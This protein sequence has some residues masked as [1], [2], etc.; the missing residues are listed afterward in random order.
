MLNTELD[1][2]LIRLSTMSAHVDYFIILESPITFTGLPK[3]LLLTESNNLERLKPYQHKIVHR[4]LEH[5]PV[6]VTRTWDYEDFQRNAMLTQGLLGIEYGEKRA[7]ED[8]V[9]IVADVDEVVRPEALLVLKYCRIPLRVTLRSQFYYYGFQFR[10]IGQQWPHPQATLYRGSSTIPPAD[11][12]N[13]EGSFLAWWQKTDLW[14]AGWHCSSCFKS[15]GQMLNKMQSFSHMRLNREKFRDKA[16]MV[17]RV[18]KGLDLW[19]RRGEFYEKVQ[20]NMDIPEIL[21]GEEGKKTFGYMLDREGPGAG[22]VDY[23]DE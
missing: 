13:G 4:V 11:L 20:E 7:R 12:R 10:H 3:P 17:D 18:R 15:V 16:R 19:D 21:K 23:M 1:W 2:L 5:I 9:L 14:D 6:N 22:F 8:D